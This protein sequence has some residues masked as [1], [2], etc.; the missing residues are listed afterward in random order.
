MSTD[1]PW[2]KTSCH[3]HMRALLPR[4]A[5]EFKSHAPS[6]EYAGHVKSPD[7]NYLTKR[8][9]QKSK[10]RSKNMFL[11]NVQNPFPWIRDT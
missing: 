11:K 2:L 1:A 6:N 3:K 10:N 9:V 7:K 8:L 5:P 4:V